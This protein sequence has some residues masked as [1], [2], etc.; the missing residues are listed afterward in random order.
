METTTIKNAKGKEF[1]VTLNKW[2][3][4]VDKNVKFKLMRE[5]DIP[6]AFKEFFGL[7][8]RLNMANVGC[9]VVV[10]NNA[11]ELVE[12]GYQLPVYIAE[13]ESGEFDIIYDLIDKG[14][15]IA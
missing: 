4:C 13:T 15:C 5:E 8:I 9:V 7:L 3:D 14:F 6:S 12:S 2:F 11:K 10:E 1:N